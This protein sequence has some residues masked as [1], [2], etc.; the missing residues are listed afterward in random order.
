M[1]QLVIA[2]LIAVAGFGAGIKW[3]AGIVAQRDLKELQESK[4]EE[5]RLANKIDNSAEKH[6]RTKARIETEFV[7][8]TERVQHVVEKPV[9]RNI[10]VDADGLRLIADAIKPAPAA[11]QPAG[12]VSGPKP[13]D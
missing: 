5:Q 3:H 12:A 2:L 1:I 10:C 9:Y 6:E 8:I 4:Q 7:T 13:A 11:S